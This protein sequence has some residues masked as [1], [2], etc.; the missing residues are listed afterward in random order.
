MRALLL[1]ALDDDDEKVRVAAASV[2][3]VDEVESALG[4]PHA[5]VRVRAAAARASVGDLRALAPLLALA[6]EK[7]PEVV[8]RRA[9][10]VDRVG[11]ALGGL[12]DL[13]AGDAA[14]AGVL[15]AVAGL[16]GHK[17]KSIR[18]TA[19][20]A[21][22][23]VSRPGGDLGPLREALAHPDEDV[24]LEAAFGLA[25]VGDPAGLPV[26]RGLTQA[27]APLALRC[28][29]AAVS[30]GRQADELLAAFMDHV[31]ERGRVC[32]PP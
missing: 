21:L 24:K 27:A 4:S 17:E 19:A 26:L 30:L 23:W 7:E 15:G 12:A 11:R 14:D 8:E 31:D 5:D 13:G 22:G 29:G 28:L 25:I 10:W 3:S 6:T 1:R 32:P 9:A 2:L 20:R 16:V 18:D